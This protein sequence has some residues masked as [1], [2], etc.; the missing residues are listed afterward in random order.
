M[1]SSAFR[2]LLT[3]SS[4]LFLFLLGGKGVHGQEETAEEFQ[5]RIRMKIQRIFNQQ[6]E[7]YAMWIGLSDPEYGDMYFVFGNS[8]STEEGSSPPDVAATLDDV[9]QIG[10]ISKTFLGTAMLL[11]ESRGD[12]SLN[13]TVQELVP[14]F[15]LEFP[16]YANYTVENLLRMETLVPDFL[17]DEEGILNDYS[18]NIS[19]RYSVEEIVAYAMQRYPLETPGYSTTNFVV[20]EF[21]VEAVTCQKIEKVIEDLVFGPLG[22]ENM[23]LPNRFSDGVLPD[24]A[25][26]TY[27]GPSCL[28]GLPLIGLDGGFEVNQD[29]SEFANGIVMVG[30]G[31][32]INSNIYDLLAWAKSGTGDDLLT[33]EMVQ[34]RHETHPYGIA[35][36][37][38]QSAGSW[39]GHDGATFGY[40]AKAWRHGSSGASF[41][42]A[43]NTCGSAI[44]VL[45][46]VWVMFVEE[47]LDR[48]LAVTLEPSMT[49]APSMTPA[50]SSTSEVSPTASPGASPTNPATSLLMEAPTSSAQQNVMKAMW[51][52]LVILG[53]LVLHLF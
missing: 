32:A 27:L 11:L 15:A 13:D 5:D 20:G 8:T 7:A 50:P 3:K 51:S 33:E 42:G 38:I 45:V 16:Q 46:R 41:A 39:Y 37:E 49:V 19:K 35:L 26:T 25:A 36:A 2:S 6:Q 31:G 28:E 14:D 44:I 48:D 29:I 17:N 18:K 53:S 9:F 34:R 21:I 10:S 52:S 47:L 30:I 43:L 40:N 23:E 24:P 22:L 4:L 12:L 1:L